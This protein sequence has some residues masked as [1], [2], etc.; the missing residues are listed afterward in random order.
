M[1]LSKPWQLVPWT[2]VLQSLCPPS[3]LNNP[4]PWLHPG[5]NDR[6]LSISSTLSIPLWPPLP[7]F[8][9]QFPLTLWLHQSFSLINTTNIL[10]LSPFHWPSPF[11][12]PPSSL[13][14]LNSIVNHYN[15][16]F[17]YTLNSLDTFSLQT[18]RRVNLNFPSVPFL[19]LCREWSWRKHTI[20]LMDLTLK[21]WPGILSGPL[22][23]LDY[24]LLFP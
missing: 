24:Y 13:L 4:F 12:S 9:A 11:T 5:F 7:T 17:A 16:S 20:T 18:T 21:S 15:H 14:K 8:L 10:I 6:D 2:P 22:V 3:Y 19:H 1:V 23:L